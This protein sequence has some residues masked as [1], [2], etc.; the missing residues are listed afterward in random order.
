[1]SIYA[2]AETHPEFEFRNC[3]GAVAGYVDGNIFCTCGKFGFALKLPSE[4]IKQL[5][6]EG[7]QPLQYFPNGHI[8]K[9]YAIL[10]E[11]VM[12]DTPQL[13]TLMTESIAFVTGRH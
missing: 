9:D 3:F 12:K 1:M 8:K 7:A 10:P 2:S 5:M 4:N 6:S 11:T 13:K